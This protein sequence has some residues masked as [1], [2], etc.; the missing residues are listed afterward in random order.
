MKETPHH[1]QNDRHTYFLAT[2]RAQARKRAS[3]PAGRRGRPA[4]I[5]EALTKDSMSTRSCR[6]R[7]V[8]FH[9]SGGRISASEGTSP[10]AGEGGGQGV[11]PRRLGR[12]ARTNS[13]RGG[14]T[15]PRAIARGPEQ[16]QCSTMARLRQ[17]PPHAT[18]EPASGQ[19]PRNDPALLADYP[20]HDMGGHVRQPSWAKPSPK[21]ALKSLDSS[22]GS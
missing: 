4:A 16:R 20:P 15:G 3:A 7:R 6:A 12:R 13:L 18:R 11:L 21:V 2:T 19:A 22:S 17:R 10:N 5:R 9:P 1:G 8:A 14:S